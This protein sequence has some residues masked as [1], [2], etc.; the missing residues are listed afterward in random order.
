MCMEE[1]LL[2]VLCNLYLGKEGIEK[3]LKEYLGLEK[4][5]WFWCGIMGDDG[6]VNGY[7]D[8]FCC[9]VCFGVVLLVWIDDEDDL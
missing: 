8:N 1:C 6:V 4:I 3:V 7:V 5:I 9:F 2:Y